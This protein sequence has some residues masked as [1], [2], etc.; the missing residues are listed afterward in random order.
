MEDDR[1]RN[2]FTAAFFLMLPLYAAAQS[3]ST[4]NHNGNEGLY[5]II[6]A[7][8][9]FIIIYLVFR[10]KANNPSQKKEDETLQKKFDEL[11]TAYVKLREEYDKLSK[12]EKQNLLK[13]SEFKHKISELEKVNVE[14]LRKK[15]E[16]EEKKIALEELQKRK[17]EIFAIAIHDIK[18]PINAIR[19]YI[20][21]IKSYDLTVQE[22]Q[23]IMESLTS[24]ADKIIQLS[25]EMSEIIEKKDFVPE[26][27]FSTFSIK[28]IIDKI[29]KINSVYVK[30][31]SITL[32][33]R[34]KENL[35]KIFWLPNKFEE[36]VDNLVNNAIKYGPHGTTVEIDAYVKD[37]FLVVEVKDNG[38]GLSK[39]D[40]AK[41]FT[42]GGILTPK[43]T[44]EETQTGLGLWLVKLMVEDRGG[45]VWVN[46][47]VGK[48][49][50]FAFSIPLNK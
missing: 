28:P 30:K 43:P 42:K 26:N 12:E 32:I 24:S 34:V 21:L 27:N 6:I 44:G 23:E 35:P 48:G 5:I 37:D 46:S 31:K 8:L 9:L 41:A 50:T 47:E 3:H 49:S 45:K 20:E 29:C 15:N 18:N 22:Q 39:E 16:L 2:K 4:P 33:N 11:E 38:V 19:G 36:T 40:I 7:L 1:T 25:Q 14:L 13:L 10:D 17:D